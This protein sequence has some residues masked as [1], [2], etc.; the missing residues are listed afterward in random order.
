MTSVQKTR[1]KNIKQD[2]KNIANSET[3]IITKLPVQKK[4]KEEIESE[5]TNLLNAIQTL[6]RFHNI[7]RSH[8]SIRDGISLSNSKSYSFMHNDLVDLKKKINIAKGNIYVAV[9]SIYSMDGDVA[10]LIDLAEICNNDNIFLIVDEAHSTG[11][12]GTKG[13]G[14]VVSLGIEGNVFA[15]LHTFGKAIGAHGAAWLGE[16]SLREFLINFCR[17]FIYTTALP[18][19]SL[20]HINF[21]YL[22]LINSP[23]R[24]K[25]LHLKISYF[26]AQIN[27]YNI[28]GLLPSDSPIQSIILPGN[29]LVSNV[30]KILNTNGFE[31]RAIM[32]PSVQEGLERIRICIHSFN[33]KDE[34]DS[35]L[36]NL[37]NVL[38]RI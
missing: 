38:K 24:I 15:R 17:T 26:K 10:P 23:E 37:K 6:L 4:S 8:A 16:S 29:R 3:G 33:S 9:E 22:F 11:V 1:K 2:N 21:A 7:E 34:I 12:I 35:L 27:N 30:A 31:V 19:H 25:D 36:K 20:L 5:E 14:L 28:K 18:I 13:E 32:H